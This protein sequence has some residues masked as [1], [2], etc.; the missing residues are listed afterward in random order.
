M[1][2]GSSPVSIKSPPELA[3]MTLE[4][5]LVTYDWENQFRSFQEA[6]RKGSFKPLCWTK[7]SAVLHVSRKYCIS[8]LKTFF[9]FHSASSVSSCSSVAVTAVALTRHSVCCFSYLRIMKHA[10]FIA[11]LSPEMCASAHPSLLEWIIDH[12][13]SL[14]ILI[15]RCCTWHTVSETGRY[16]LRLCFIHNYITGKAR[17][18]VTLH[19][20]VTLGNVV[21]WQWDN[22]VCLSRLQHRALWYDKMPV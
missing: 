7:M 3:N 10:V 22:T 14:R 17:H 19:S 8:K 11:Q 12:S 20:R 1:E 18:Q 9:P 6:T 13:F 21:S 15:D 5:R 2:R 16:K 4:S